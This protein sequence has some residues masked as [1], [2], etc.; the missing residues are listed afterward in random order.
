M[1][2]LQVRE[3]GEELRQLVIGKDKLYLFSNPSS[4]GLT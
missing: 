1:S 4:L 3:L 2:S